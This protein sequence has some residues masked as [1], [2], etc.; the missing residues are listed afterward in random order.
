MIRNQGREWKGFAGDLWET[1]IVHASK[2][3]FRTIKAVN[4]MLAIGVLDQLR[5]ISEGDREV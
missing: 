2:H 3:S 4:F 1:S 5:Q